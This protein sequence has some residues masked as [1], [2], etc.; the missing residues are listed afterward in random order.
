MVNSASQIAKNDDEPNKE[1]DEPKEEKF[2]LL[3]NAE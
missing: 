2:T 3:E 1:D